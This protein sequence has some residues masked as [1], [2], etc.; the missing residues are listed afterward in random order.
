MSE[1]VLVAIIGLV[2]VAVGAAVTGLLQ[3]KKIQA[4]ADKDC[5]E[6]N[7]QIRQTVMQ[8]LTPLTNRVDE[9]ERELKD[10]KAWAHAL[11]NQLKCLGHEPVPFKPT[12]RD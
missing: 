5:A 2:G 3:R 12:K 4:E 6:T 1:T 7:E 8:L 10:W 11:V 9:L